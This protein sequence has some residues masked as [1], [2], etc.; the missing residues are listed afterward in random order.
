MGIEVNV[1]AID[2]YG[3]VQG[4]VAKNRLLRYLAAEESPR[5][6]IH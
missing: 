2:D 1:P 6:A 5:L 3:M 4:S